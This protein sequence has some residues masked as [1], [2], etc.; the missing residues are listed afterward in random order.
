VVARL[1]RQS[2]HSVE[3]LDV[4]DVLV[5]Q[6]THLIGHVGHAATARPRNKRHARS[7]GR[8]VSQSVRQAVSQSVSRFVVERLV[9]RAA[10]MVVRALM[11][12]WSLTQWGETICGG[13]GTGASS[14]CRAATCQSSGRIVSGHPLLACLFLCRRVREQCRLPIGQLISSQLI[15]WLSSPLVFPAQLPGRFCQAERTGGFW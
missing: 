14:S 12:G 6:E 13:L 15:L 2:T 4:A 3:A 10:M 11:P 1:R 9:Y 5:D 7:L 8:A